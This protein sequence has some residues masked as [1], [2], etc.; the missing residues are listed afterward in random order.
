MLERF[1][2][3]KYFS[4]AIV[5]KIIGALILI[6]TLNGVITSNVLQEMLPFLVQL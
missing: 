2:P 4:A 6:M 5:S 3:A 1:V